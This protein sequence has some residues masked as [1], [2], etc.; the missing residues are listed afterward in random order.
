V[1]NLK[2][3]YSKSVTSLKD[4]SGFTLI[5]LLVVIIIL[6]ILASI[7]IVSVSTARGNAVER[8]CQ[9]DA[10]NI[11]QALDQYFID[12][13]G[14]FPSATS[15][16][17]YYLA[18]NLSALIPNSATAPTNKFYIRT[19]PPLRGDAAGEDYYLQINVTQSSTVV[20]SVNTIQGYTTTSGSSGAASTTITACVVP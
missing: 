4:E 11:R 6:G 16:N 19:L 9:T 2:F 5:E 3:G 14:T 17:T 1:R 10:V 13:A 20:S 7:T 18:A 8:A 12:N 15:T